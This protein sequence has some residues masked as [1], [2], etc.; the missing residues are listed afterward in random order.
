MFK[1]A[2]V[3]GIQSQL[4]KNDR[5]VYPDTK[6]ASE[7][8]DYIA[9]NVD[10]DPGNVT[11]DKVAE[12]ANHLIDASNALL[13]RGFSAGPSVKT[14]SLQSLEKLA[15]DNVIELMHKAA[16]GSTIEGGDK[17]NKE[18][19]TGEGKM[20][21]SARPAG[22]AENS[23]GS[24]AV[25]TKPGAVGA[26]SDNPNK[27]SNSPA[28]SNSITEQRTAALLSAIKV[29]M[30][31]TIAGGD[32]GNTEPTTGEGKMDAAARP[33]GYAVLPHR[34]ADDAIKAM[35]GGAAVIGKEVAHPNQ[36]ANTPGGSNSIVAQTKA[37]NEDPYI[38]LFK[39]VAA[40][41]HPFLPAAAPAEQKVAHVRAM[42][43][44]DTTEKAAFIANLYKVAGEMPPWLAEK[45]EE[46]A[47]GKDEEK[48][49]KKEEKKEEKME[50][51]K[52]AS[53]LDVFKSIAK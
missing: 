26:E 9:D 44:M 46:K 48:G 39:K 22:Y 36:V 37:A 53:L 49:E 50:E 17:G 35:V 52:E 8:A 6:V 51:K 31:S 14:A 30:G 29:A 43:G 16:E 15:H 34:G 32:K 18:P 20:D 38:A 13:D 19:T 28:G 1:R 33:D 3:R 21:S 40:E 47:E 11:Y 41:V 5:A 23:Q 12:L 7:I 45:K 4:V 10:F 24:T 2:F 42:M 25:D 27:A